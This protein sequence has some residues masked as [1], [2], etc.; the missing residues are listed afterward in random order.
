M[1][2]G[3]SATG[4]VTINVASVNDA[5]VVSGPI[6]LGSVAEDSGVLTISSAQL[7]AN[8]SDVDGQPLSVDSL[9]L[10]TP[11]AVR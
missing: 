6:N 8:A 3:G 1:V 9:V 2:R 11:A 5:P 4:T 7:L 10:A